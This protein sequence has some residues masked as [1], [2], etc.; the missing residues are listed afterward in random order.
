MEANPKVILTEDR[1][2]TFPITH[3]HSKPLLLNK[4]ASIINSITRLDLVVLL[5]KIVPK[6]LLV[7][8]EKITATHRKVVEKKTK[9]EDMRGKCLS[10]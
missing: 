3:F 5:K 10:T 2:N 6:P 9:I 8:I 1:S 4:T 7:L